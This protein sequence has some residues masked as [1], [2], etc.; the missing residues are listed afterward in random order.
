ML[1]V[2]PGLAELNANGGKYNFC[3]ASVSKHLEFNQTICLNTS[4]LQFESLYH[5]YNS[6]PVHNFFKKRPCVF[7]C[8]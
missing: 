5:G 2:H 1:Q 3:T 8:Q 4:S 6:L 7:N